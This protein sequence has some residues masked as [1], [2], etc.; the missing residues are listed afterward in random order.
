[1]SFNKWK[2]VHS[3]SVPVSKINDND[4]FSLKKNSGNISIGRI[5]V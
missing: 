3:H 1:M 5:I 2:K 4:P